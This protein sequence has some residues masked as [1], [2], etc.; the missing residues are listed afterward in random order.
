MQKKFW[1]GMKKLVRKS[2]IFFTIFFLFITIAHA[3]DV[4]IER[5]FLKLPG[6]RWI[7]LKKVDWH[8]TRIILGEGKKLSE[9]GVWSHV[10]ETDGH[11]HTWAYAFFIKIKNNQ[12]IIDGKNGYPQ[13]AISTYDIGANVIRYAIIYR[14]KEDRLEMIDEIAN[15]NAAADENLLH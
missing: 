12:F 8:A 1:L 9:N 6:N 5:D 15:F 13:V 10:Y 4:P 14:V 2:S 3:G 7:W 11:R